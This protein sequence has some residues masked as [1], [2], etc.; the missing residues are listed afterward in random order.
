MEGSCLDVNVLSGLS[1][2]GCRLVDQALIYKDMV[3]L[4]SAGRCNVIVIVTV[5]MAMV[6]VVFVMVVITVMMIVVVA[7]IVMVVSVIMAV[8]VRVIVVVFPMTVSRARL[9]TDVDMTSLS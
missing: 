6:M 2:R 5:V 4:E 1:L 7:M 8:V 3:F 9:A